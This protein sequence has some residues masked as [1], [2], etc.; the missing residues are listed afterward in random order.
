MPMLTVSLARLASGYGQQILP[1]KCQCESE[2]LVMGVDHKEKTTPT[3]RKHWL[4]PFSSTDLVQFLLK[5]NTKV[6]MNS[7]PCRFRNLK[8]AGGRCHGDL[9]PPEI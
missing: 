7:D 6:W 1:A 4:M 3:P 9:V 5:M 2:E 8:G